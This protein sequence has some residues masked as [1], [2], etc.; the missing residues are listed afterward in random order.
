MILI[1]RRRVRRIRK[2]ELESWNV[3][4]ACRLAFKIDMEL[5]GLRGVRSVTVMKQ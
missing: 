4:V 1:R 3:L 2:A 5:R